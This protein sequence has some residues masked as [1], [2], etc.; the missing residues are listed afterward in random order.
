MTIVVA[1]AL[2]ALPLVTGCD[3]RVQPASGE[4]NAAVP[5][6]APSA[7]G[8]TCATTSHCANGLHCVESV[9]RPLKYSRLGDFY[10]ASGHAA[11]GRGDGSAASEA[12]GK[13]IGAYESANLTPPASL[14]CDAGMALR[15]KKGDAKASEQAA[16]LLHRC[17]LAAVPGTV[18][19]RLALDELA[20]L[21]PEGLEPT[22]LAK[23]APGDMYLTRP[24]AK[25]VGDPKVQIAPGGSPSRDKGYAAFIA[26]AAGAQAPLVD[27]WKSYSAAAQKPLLSVTLDLKYRQILGDDD[28][29]EGARLELNGTPP[30]GAEGTAFACVKAALT[31]V[32]DEIAKDKRSSSGDWQGNVV[33]MV[34]AP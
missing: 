26:K 33:V 9:C 22:L 19:Y 24:S 21:E 25:P 13:A 29:V 5:G 32:A 17:V 7:E 12:F 4:T 34:Q 8:E 15:R 16:R 3:P 20:A 2:A 1:L 30:A 18:D 23:D 28:I 11:V 10:Q 27:C 6:V 14:L 31:P